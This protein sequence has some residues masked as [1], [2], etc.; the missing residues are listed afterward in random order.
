MRVSGLTAAC[1]EVL[2]LVGPI[3]VNL[4]NAVGKAVQPVSNDGTTGFEMELGGIGG[5]TDAEGL[6]LGHR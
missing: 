2:M 4:G 3:G 5:A 1:G 6:I